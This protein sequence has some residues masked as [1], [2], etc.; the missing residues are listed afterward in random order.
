MNK[1]LIIGSGGREHALAWKLVSDVEVGEVYC[2]PGNGGTQNIACNVDLKIDD[3]DAIHKYVCNEA[4]DMIIVGPEA[5]LND[6]IVDFFK[7]K[8]IKIF[9]PDQFASQ[10]ECSKLFARDFM[11]E[12]DIPQ[13]KYYECRSIDQGYQIKAELGLPLV[14]KAD[15]L[16]AGKGVLICNSESEFENG[17]KIMFDDKKFGSACEKISIEQCLIGQELSVFAVCDGKN[18]KIIGDA[19]DHKRIFDED[20]GPNTGGMGAYSPTSLCSPELLRNVEEDIIKPTLKGMSD[21]DHPYLGFLYVGLMIVEGKPFVIEFN[22]RM[23]D[24]ETQVVIPRIESSLYKIFED[25]ING[26]IDKTDISF[27]SD[28]FVAVVLASKGYPD[29]YVTGQNIGEIKPLDNNILFHAGTK[30]NNQKHYVSG[31]RVLNA[32]GFGESIDKAISNV[33]KFISGIEFENM[34]FR[35]DIGQKGLK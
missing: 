23:G 8:N 21:L 7:D 24:P 27:S 4:I 33:Y 19:Q 29:K 5:P 20:K 13:P 6:G 12:N 1:V 32:V 31:G 2:L 14:L 15:G 18:Y 10:L 11:M 9:G 26:N 28:T 22:V 30:F 35:K 3:F 25:S 17:L 34:Y 16:A